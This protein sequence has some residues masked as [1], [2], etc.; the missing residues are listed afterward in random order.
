MITGECIISYPA[1][2]EPKENPSG[3]LKY[4]CSLLFDKEDTKSIEELQEA[5]NKAIARGKEKI[6]N[7]R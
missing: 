2:F 1:I 7:I 5:I 3:A 6:W 4:S